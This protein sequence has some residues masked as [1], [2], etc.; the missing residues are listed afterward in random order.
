MVIA[1]LPPEGHLETH[2]CHQAVLI[3]QFMVKARARVI[4]MV[5][6]L[7]TDEKILLKSKPSTCWKP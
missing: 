3:D 2:F 1:F 7:M 4:L 5:T 6:S